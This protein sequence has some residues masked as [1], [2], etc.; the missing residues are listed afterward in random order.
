MNAVVSRIA[1]GAAL[2][3]SLAAPAVAHAECTAWT[4]ATV[5]PRGLTM[6]VPSG[7]GIAMRPENDG[8]Q[9]RLENRSN[10]FFKVKLITGS[11]QPQNYHVFVRPREIASIAVRVTKNAKEAAAPIAVSV[12]WC[13]DGG[14]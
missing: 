8:Q 3:L 12:Q 7:G 10:G 5:T 6:S 14:E 11:V 1:A 2:A 9:L 13:S 4:A